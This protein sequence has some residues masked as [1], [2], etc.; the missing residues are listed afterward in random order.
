MA[1]PA[2]TFPAMNAALPESEYTIPTTDKR[3][4]EEVVVLPRSARA[5]RTVSLEW[6]DGAGELHCHELSPELSL[7]WLS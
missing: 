5:P 7:A 3:E 2:I 6:R 1:A 4:L